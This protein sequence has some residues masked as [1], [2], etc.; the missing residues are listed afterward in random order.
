MDFTLFRQF[1][2][3]I[4]LEVLKRC[5]RNDLVC[6]SLTSH[7]LRLLSTPLITSKPKLEWVD[8][9][10]STADVP[11]GCPLDKSEM[12][13]RSTCE[14][15][16]DVFVIR[17]IITLMIIQCA[18]CR[19]AR[20]IVFVFLVLCLRDYGGGWGR[21]SIV[22]IVASLL[23]DIRGTREDACMEDERLER[24]LIT[25][26]RIEKDCLM[27]AGGGENGGRVMST[28][29]HTRPMRTGARMRG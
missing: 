2:P 22:L 21:E 12:D 23:S 28:T 1:P 15:F 16:L 7:E 11:H 17:A 25:S 6:L 3:E 29:R 26:G 19:I 27:A 10:G 8:Q 24:R 5:A 20:N 14:G 18:M 4:Q 9:L 13:Y